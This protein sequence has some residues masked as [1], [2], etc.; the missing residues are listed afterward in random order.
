MLALSSKVKMRFREDYY[1]I[2]K[3]LAGDL[4]AYGLLVQKHEKVAFTLAKRILKNKEEA[5]E[6]TQDAFLKAYQSLSSFKGN[7]KFTTWLYKIIYNEALGRIRKNKETTIELDSVCEISSDTTTYLDGLRTLQLL[8]R[9]S[10]IQKGLEALKPKEAA[11][12]TLFYLEEQSIKEIE[13][14]M[15]LSSSNIKILLHRGRKSL[16]EAIQQLTNSELIHLL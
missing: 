7:S 4:N 5:E 11:A 12:L 1:Y 13:V 14:I 16:L 2:D 9:R 15:N 3:T 10:L 8:E 6:A